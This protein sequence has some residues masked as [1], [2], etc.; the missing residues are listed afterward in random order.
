[1]NMLKDL[2]IEAAGRMRKAAGTSPVTLKVPAPNLTH[3]S[4]QT[5]Q[6]VQRSRT[7][8]ARICVSRRC[9]LA[10]PKACS[11]QSAMPTWTSSRRSSQT[12]RPRPR[13]LRAW[14]CPSCAPSCVTTRTTSNSCSCVPAPC[15]FASIVRCHAV[16]P[17]LH[18]LLFHRGSCTVLS[19]STGSRKAPVLATAAGTARCA[20]PCACSPGVQG[21]LE[22]LLTAAGGP[23][24]ACGAPAEP[25]HPYSLTCTAIVQDAS[26]LQ[27]MLEL[28]ETEAP[29]TEDFY[30]RHST[31]QLLSRLVS[32]APQTLQAAVLDRQQVRW[33]FLDAS[34]SR[35]FLFAPCCMRLD[36][37]F[38]TD[39]RVDCVCALE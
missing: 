25:E 26:S 27:L 11:P 14:A 32:A 19:G 21:A 17:G 22:V 33:H 34:A 36:W 3:R 29:L 28:P 15:C 30:V 16:A 35:M 18:Q 39:W 4:H 1:M 31:I 38:C 7:P 5:G 13:P 24:E 37:E 10:S 9:S 8:R 6:L 2:A 23:L 20:T 12:A